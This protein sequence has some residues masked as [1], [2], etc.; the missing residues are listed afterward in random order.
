[1]ITRARRLSSAAALGGVVCAALALQACSNSGSG[2]ATPPSAPSSA[3]ASQT[4]SLAPAG[5]PLDE[6]LDK[7][8]TCVDKG[9]VNRGCDA[10]AQLSQAVNTQR[11]T[12]GVVENLLSAAEGKEPSRKALALTMLARPFP[13]EADAA[14]RLLKLLDAETDP[15]FKSD[16]LEALTPRTAAGVPEAAL[17]LLVSAEE[18]N[19]R[20]AACRLLGS[21]AHE[22][23]AELA[24]PALL[25]ALR[26]DQA[27]AV[28]RQ[29]ATSVGNLLFADALPDL[30][31]TLDDPLV[32]PSATFALARFE[33]PEAYDAIWGRI[34]AGI[35]DGKVSLPLLASI[36]LLEKH[37]K[38][39]QKRE[40]KTLEKLKKVLEKAPP[41]DGTAQAG[42]KLVQ[43]N[44]DRMTGKAPEPGMPLPGQ[45]VPVAPPGGVPAGKPKVVAPGSQK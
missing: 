30:I 37:P 32:A 4:A 29:A 16:L 6:L 12:P 28:R 7:A 33:T 9:R 34:D 20:A 25:K 10:Y 26:E 1:M 14:L 18:P 22:A 43:R 36:R 19:I 31:K 8:L 35:K 2:S 15:A 17:K 42:L 44:I 24:K 40:L 38:H 23:S 3:L 45:L 11:R 5:G 13:D 27:P 39:D 21:K 41:T